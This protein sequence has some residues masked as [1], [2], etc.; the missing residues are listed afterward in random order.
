MFDGDSDASLVIAL[1]GGSHFVNHT[2]FMLLPPIF[3]PLQSELGLTDPQLG[4]ALGTV[5]LVVTALQLPFGHL[6]DTY[7]RTPV[8]AISLT[9]GALGAALIATASSFAWLLAGAV[10]TGVGIA[11]HHPAHYPLISSVTDASTRGRAYSVHGFTGT[12]GFAA[13]PAAVGAALAFGVDWRLAIGAFAVLGALYGA[14]CLLTFHRYVDRSITHP[15]AADDEA[16]SG[17]T[18]LQRLAAGVRSVL[19]SP[20]ILA[21]TALW[22]ASSMAAWGIKQYTAPMLAGLYGLS[23][24]S[25][26]IAVSAMLGTGAVL[27]FGGGWL[28]DRYTPGL[29]LLVGYVALVAVAGVLAVG[30]LPTALAVGL[31][32]FLSATIDASRPARA[33]LADRFSSSAT[34]GKNF[35]LLTIG[36]SGGS[37]VAPP[38]LGVVVQR[39]G[40]EVAFLAVA[41]IGLLAI[42]LTAVVLRLDAGEPSATPSPSD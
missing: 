25:A 12:I 20:P 21:L 35:G 4:L 24:G 7:G 29:V 5:G 19:G 18:R 10:V 38:V 15:G 8:L 16:S 41:A 17:G 39:Y 28:T 22:F 23:A 36:I 9:F 31:V 1:I 6:S 14:V 34:A 42:A 2:Y 27:I 3:G 32:L 30:V 26:N 40:L 37:A 33:A 11:G 13:P